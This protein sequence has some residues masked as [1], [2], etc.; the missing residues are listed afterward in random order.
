M[1]PLAFDVE[2]DGM[3]E[4]FVMKEG[5]VSFG[6]AAAVEAMEADIDAFW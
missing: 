6:D 2:G 5:M 4:S 1:L 3:L